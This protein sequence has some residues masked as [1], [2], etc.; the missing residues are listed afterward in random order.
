[1]KRN[2]WRIENKLHYVREVTYGEDSSRVRTAGAPRVT[3]S[4]RNLVIGILCL[5]GN[6][7]I[8]AA[9]RHT[10]RDVTRPLALPGIHA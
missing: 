9:L 3:A 2:H 1:V 7:D 10:A 8:A 4:F 5:A 6:T